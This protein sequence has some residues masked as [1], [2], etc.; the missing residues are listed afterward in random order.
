MD[1]NILLLSM[2]IQSTGHASKKQTSL[3]PA[4]GQSGKR[5]KNLSQ[6]PLGQRLTPCISNLCIPKHGHLVGPAVVSTQ[7]PGW[8]TRGAV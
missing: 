2:T 5:R 7:E 3:E 8:E 4:I 6:A 1:K